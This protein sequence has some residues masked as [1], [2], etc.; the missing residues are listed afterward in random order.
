[1]WSPGNVSLASE[2]G[3][4]GHSIVFG[5]SLVATWISS[6]RARTTSPTSRSE[7]PSP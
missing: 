2:A 5:G 4:P 6:D 3:L 7:C 1:M